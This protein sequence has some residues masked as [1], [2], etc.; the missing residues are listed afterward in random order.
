V[1]IL[2]HLQQM[3]GIMPQGNGSSPFRLSH[4]SD[5]RRGIRTLKRQ[6][7]KR[8]LSPEK[9]QL[10]ECELMEMEK[11]LNAQW[12]QQRRQRARDTGQPL[13]LILT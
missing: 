12:R 13:P 11:E 3:E 5:L 10:F 6:L 7:Q 9:I 4:D 8:S 1:S 2:V